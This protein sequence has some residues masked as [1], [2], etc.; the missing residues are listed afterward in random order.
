MML[1]WGLG[2]GHERP[3][4]L[5]RRSSLKE[6]QNLEMFKEADTG[7]EGSDGH[8]TGKERCPW[9]KKAPTASLATPVLP[10]INHL[11]FV[12]RALFGWDPLL[13]MALTAGAEQTYQGPSFYPH[14]LKSL[15]PLLCLSAAWED[16]T[17]S[18]SLILLI[19]LQRKGPSAFSKPNPTPRN[20]RTLHVLKSPLQH[21]SKAAFN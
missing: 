9:D 15:R 1:E 13:L 19:E 12:G 6:I 18:P 4:H 20:L 7:L 2:P 3:I 5:A 11:G 21:A 14:G 16:S 17:K 8:W 10:L